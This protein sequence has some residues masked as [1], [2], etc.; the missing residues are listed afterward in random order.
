M[1]S[2][3]LLI[4]LLTKRVQI[5]EPAFYGNVMIYRNIIIITLLVSILTPS[6]KNGRA[7]VKN[8]GNGPFLKAYQLQLVGEKQFPLDKITAPRPA[9]LQYYKDSETGE[10]RL[11]FLNYAARKIY[12]YNYEKG[13]ITDTI[14]LNISPLKSF[15]S[16]SAYYVKSAD[17]LYIFDDVGQKAALL[18]SKLL[19]RDSISL[20]GKMNSA[21]VDWTLHYP[22]YFF[23]AAAPVMERNGQLVLTGMYPWAIPDSLIN[24]F[25]L[26]SVLDIGTKQVSY[27]NSYPKTLFGK[28]FDWD[29]PFFTAASSDFG[30]QSNMLLLSFPISHDLYISNLSLGKM[31]RIYAGSPDA[32]PITSIGK[33]PVGD[34]TFKEKLAKSI[35][36]TDLYGGIKYDKYRKVY[37]RFLRKALPEGNTETNWKNKVLSVIMMDTSFKYLGETALGTLKE[38]NWENSFVSE[39]G[40]NIEYIDQENN[41]EDYLTFKI[42]KPK[43]KI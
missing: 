35:I 5:L 13:M 20:I 12:I 15:R 19:V 4:R 40:L 2:N 34:K 10:A 1:L 22:Q 8:E 27:L 37:Y 24:T 41:N 16:L 33:K 17:S 30:H 6:C 23:S 32:R 18:D 7:S 11:S 3:K 39:A 26:N 28:N 14:S 31:D 36:N 42:F 29:D 21:T 43:K 9:Y 38:W 25:K